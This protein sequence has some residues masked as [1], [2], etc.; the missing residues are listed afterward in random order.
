MIGASRAASGRSYQV[1]S[2]TNITSTGSQNYTVPE[3]V[4]YLEVEMYGAEMRLR[5]PTTQS[6]KFCIKK[7]QSSISGIRGVFADNHELEW[8]QRENRL[9]FEYMLPA[10]EEVI[11]SVK[12]NEDTRAVEQN[13][14]WKYRVKTMLRRYLSEFRDNYVLCYLPNILTR[15]VKVN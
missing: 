14:R 9:L 2:T 8:E 13:V 15:F 12:C 5:N 10:N 4:V 6:L 7:R 3:G 1:L 11:I